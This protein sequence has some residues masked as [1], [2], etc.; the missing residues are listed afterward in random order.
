MDSLVATLEDED[1][2]VRENIVNSLVEIGDS[3]AID[4]LISLLGDE[5]YKVRKS[6]ADGLGKFGDRRAVEPLL[7]ALETERE[8]DV[9]QSEVLALGELGGQQT[10]EGLSRVSTDMD[11]YRFVRIAAEG[12]LEKLKGGGAENTS[13]PS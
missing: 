10:I 5:N 1:W 6:A 9:R 13:S 7:K 11:E 2:L 12:A 3:R 8:R 4:P